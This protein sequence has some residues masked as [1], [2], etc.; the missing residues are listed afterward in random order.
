MPVDVWYPISL[1][2]YFVCVCHVSICLAE[3]VGWA[4][5]GV[6]EIKWACPLSCPSVWLPSVT[7]LDEIRGDLL[8]A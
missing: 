6:G 1:Y 4:Q 2:L 3:G 8:S 7:L 5:M